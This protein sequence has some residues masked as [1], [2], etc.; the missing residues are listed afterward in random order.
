[1]AAFPPQL[2]T[3]ALLIWAGTATGAADC[4]EEDYVQRPGC[5]Q[6]RSM[7]NCSLQE[8]SMRAQAL[9]ATAFG[10]LGRMHAQGQESS[11]PVPVLVWGRG[12]PGYFNCLLSVCLQGRVKTRT[13]RALCIESVQG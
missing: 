11:Q 5:Q 10:C 3:P 6:P 2:T 8:R 12:L 1:M 4:E 7:Q 9:E 13:L